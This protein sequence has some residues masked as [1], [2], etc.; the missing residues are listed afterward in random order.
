MTVLAVI[1]RSRLFHLAVVPVNL[2]NE[3]SGSRLAENHRKG[4]PMKFA[5][6]VAIGTLLAMPV[7]AAPGGVWNDGTMLLGQWGEDDFGYEGRSDFAGSGKKMVSIGVQGGAILANFW[8][9]D[10]DDFLGSDSDDPFML[11][12]GGDAFLGVQLHK[13]FKVQA[14]FGF[15]RVGTL[16][17]KETPGG[18]WEW[19]ISMD[20][21]S[22][23]IIAVATIPTGSPVTPRIFGGVD[24]SIYIDGRTYMSW[25]GSDNTEEIKPDAVANFNVGFII[26][27]GCE[28]D[29][30]SGAYLLVDVRYTFLLTKFSDDD[31][32]WGTDLE[33]AKHEFFSFSVGFGYKVA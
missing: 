30:Q 24:L 13:Y 21:F 29:L 16:A 14:G 5:I 12:F 10:W 19:E 32:Y 22:M 27:F 11:A 20:Y 26:G 3:A 17:E 7:Y 18:D 25:S 1:A 9:E 8:D 15:R 23:P 28:F 2:Q 4:A 6:I 31:T 33:D